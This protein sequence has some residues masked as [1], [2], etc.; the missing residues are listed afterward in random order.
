MTQ[1]TKFSD[2]SHARVYAHW[3]TY[4]AWRTLSLAAK[5]ILI[6][7][8]ME[9]RVGINGTLAW[10]CRR[11]ARAINVSKDTAARALTDLE[12]RGW[13]TVER[14]ASFGRRNAPAQYAVTMFP[15]DV[16]GEPASHAFEVW[17]PDGPAFQF[18][19]RV[20]PRGRDG[21]TTGT[22]PSHTR[23]AKAVSTGPL[24]V[25]ESLKSS[26]AFKG[27]GENPG[28]GGEG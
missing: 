24:V 19:A 8:L 23:D 13:L 6:E 3:R 4:P 26:R 1:A 15:N 5:C 27:L 22:R 12:C 11:A 20:A 10:S 17:R 14:V 9:N 21:R 18:L 7:I 25:S 2:R 28:L 16:T